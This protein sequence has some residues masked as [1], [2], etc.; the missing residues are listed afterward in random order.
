MKK[1]LSII[2][3]GVM[4]AMTPAVSSYADEKGADELAVEG[5]SKLLDALSVFID[6][7]PQYETPE[8]LDNGDIIIRRVPSTKEDKDTDD[9]DHGVEKTST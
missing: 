2:G 3:L 9:N 7:I 6:S 1:K 5:L 8:V 4:L